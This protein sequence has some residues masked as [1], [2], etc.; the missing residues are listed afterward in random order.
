MTLAP[1]YNVS[2][3]LPTLIVLFSGAKKVSLP[4]PATKLSLPLSRRCH[5]AFPV[6]RHREAVCGLIG[7]SRSEAAPAL[8][9]DFLQIA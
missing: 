4:L 8:L 6:Q 1:K 2:L 7:R 5:G 3:P 9:S